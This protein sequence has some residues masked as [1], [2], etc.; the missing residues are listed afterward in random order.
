MPHIL[1]FG[2]LLL[3]L[4]PPG[5]ERLL[6]SARFD[7]SVGGCEANVAAGLAQ[8]DVPVQYLTRLPDNAIA[9]GALRALRAEGVGTKHV[10]RGGDRMGLYFLELGA[11]VRGLRTVYDRAFS[12]FAGITPEQAPF[13][14]ALDG[15]SWLHTSGIVAAL[16]DSAYQTLEAGIV[17]ARAAGVRTSIDCNFRPSLWQGKNPQSL[18]LPLMPHVDLLIGNPGA[19]HEM[20]GEPTSGSMPEPPEALRHTAERLHRRFGME[21]IAITQREVRDA[22]THAW[23]A[24]LW[25]AADGVLLEGGWYVVRVVDRVG[26]GD[27]FAAGLLAA[28]YRDVPAAD[29]IRFATAAGAHK[30]TVPGDFPRTTWEEI[31]GM[32]RGR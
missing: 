13:D 6:Q 27:A 17:Q 10:I 20:L 16:G 14:R 4:S 23:R 18:M 24:W 21:R 28:L 26:G 3:R 25:Q 1:T 12:A 5:N 30:L 2:E 15:A 7:V 9:D 8:F 19:F 29:A 22:S 11:D 32:Q 31:E